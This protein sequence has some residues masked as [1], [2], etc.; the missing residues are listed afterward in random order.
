METKQCGKCK[1][2]KPV[3]DFCKDKNSK[4]GL[5]VTYRRV[6]SPSQK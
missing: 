5:N 1:Q 3:A 2:I 4:D 6:G